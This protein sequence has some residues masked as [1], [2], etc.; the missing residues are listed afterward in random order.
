MLVD[1]GKPRLALPHLD[2]VLIDIDGH[3]LEEYDPTLAMNGL[4]LAWLALEA[5]TDQK[6][7]EQATDVLHRIGRL[8]LPE[9]VRLAKD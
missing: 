6:F 8:D 7:K 9:M 2:Q 3:G 5:Q 4:R 1:V